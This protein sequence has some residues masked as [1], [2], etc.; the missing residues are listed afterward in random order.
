MIRQDCGQSGAE[1]STSPVPNLEWWWGVRGGWGVGGGGGGEGGGRG[2]FQERS[3]HS[4]CWVGYSR[5]GQGWQLAWSCGR[6]E[7][8]DAQ[9]SV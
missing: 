6:V 7:T 3:G 8:R 1:N 4:Q 2:V 5:V 9:A